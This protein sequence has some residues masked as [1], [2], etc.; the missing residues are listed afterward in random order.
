M[1]GLKT[2]EIKTSLIQIKIMIDT[3]VI[4]NYLSYLENDDF[5]N[6]W[7]KLESNKWVFNQKKIENKPKLT[8]YCDPI[9]IWHLSADV[10]LPKF[11]F[12]H[13]ARLPNEAEVF[14]GLV[15]I[16]K[17][18]ESKSSLDFDPFSARVWR[19]D[20]TKDFLFSESRISELIYKLS[21]K[22]LSRMDKLFYNDSTLYFKAKTKEIRI[23]PKY[24]EVLSDKTN[25]AEA[26]EMAKG[27]LRF[28]VKLQ[29]YSLNQFV[30]KNC[31]PDKTADILLR[32]K[33][34]NSVISEGLEKVDFCHILTNEKTTLDILL[35]DFPLK[36]AKDLYFFLGMYRE[37][38]ENFYKDKSLGISKS[39]Y[40]RNV[41]DCRK[42]KVWN[43]EK[44]LE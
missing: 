23:Y 40:N 12:G 5:K 8:L 32:N 18:V 41:K 10:S 1:N 2:A 26:F 29:K 42:A 37:R 15:K 19:V 38:G 3:I 43:H 31:L 13:N 11:L 4:K 7:L 44:L 39:G 28:E 16:G 22:N 17:Y 21:K 36:R 9:G 14:E 34:S 20:F 6:H 25:P 33:V 27:K 24:R 35:E 30:K